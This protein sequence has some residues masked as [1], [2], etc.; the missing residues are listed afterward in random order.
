[1]FFTY[2]RKACKSHCDTYIS[3][4]PDY[5]RELVEPVSSAQLLPLFFFLSSLANTLYL[6][7]I[8]FYTRT[9]YATNTTISLLLRS[10]TSHTDTIDATEDGFV[11]SIF[12]SFFLFFFYYFSFPSLAYVWRQEREKH[13]SVTQV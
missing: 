4:C 3:F 11:S 2:T 7:T 13:N 9:F 10:K 1:M 12:A 6:D 8:A 5:V